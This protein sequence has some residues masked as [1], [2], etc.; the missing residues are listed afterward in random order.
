MM[1]QLLPVRLSYNGREGAD[2][3]VAGETI[4]LSA[5]GKTPE[6]AM[7]QITAMHQ[8]A[9]PNDRIELTVTS[10]EVTFPR[11]VPNEEFANLIEGIA[12]SRLLIPSRI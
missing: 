6:E 11:G 9:F 1:T 5:I 7:E 2:W 12:A 10:L 8:R 3:K 4:S